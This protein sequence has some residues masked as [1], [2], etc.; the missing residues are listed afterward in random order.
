MDI[1]SGEWFY[2]RCGANTCG[3]CLPRNVADR[4]LAIAYAAPERWLRFSLVGDDHQTR[5]GRMKQLVYSIREA[6]YATE[7]VWYAEPNP[8]GTGYHVH[9]H[10]HGDFLPQRELVELADSV[11]MGRNTDIR[12]WHSE[13]GTGHAY[14]MKQTA[15]YGMKDAR[16]RD[17]AAARYLEDNGGRL[18]H[19][20][21]GFFRHPDGTP[22][23]NVK[24]AVKAARAAR[25]SDGSNWVLIRHPEDP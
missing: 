3:Y 4:A 6:G 20:T 1:T 7:L 16:S 9:A 8:K 25:R 24:A 22:I 21:R 14:G 19:H 2:A 23:G 10:Q 12:A 15:G 5:R 18:H 11:G 13:G 17:R